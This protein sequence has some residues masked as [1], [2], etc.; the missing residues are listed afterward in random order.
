MKLLV[1]AS[2]FPYPLQ[3][4]DQL[5]LYHQIKCLAKEFEIFLY[6]TSNAKVKEKEIKELEKYCT[7]IK[8]H[9]LST[10]KMASNTIKAF[11]GSLPLQVGMFTSA[12]IQGEIK[13]FAEEHNIDH[14]YCQ[15]IRMAQNVKVLKYP[16][17]IDYMDAF[18]YGM[19]KRSEMGGIVK[20]MLYTFE[21]KRVKKY[22]KSIYESFANHVIITEQ[23]KNRLEVPGPVGVVAN[24][25]DTEFF[26][27]AG[28]VLEYDI[29]FVGNMGYLPNIDAAKM[30]VNEIL[31][32][33]NK[34]LGTNVSVLIAGARPTQ[35]V[36]DLAKT[37]NVTIGGWVQDIR[38]AYKSGR[39]FVAPIFKGIGQQNKIL[40]AMSMEIPCIVNDSVAEGLG[41]VHEK[42]CL[43]ANT[44]DEFV[45]TIIRLL[46]E[47]I[48][49]TSI[50]VSAKE[51]VLEKY[52]W[53][54]QTDPLI[55][56]IKSTGKH[57]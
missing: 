13:A 27:N 22:E 23:D 28:G 1:V 21:S 43:I 29:L 55:Q 35:E 51:L 2:R 31:P 45:D 11:F 57:T 24:G 40:E 32:K 19:V 26:T 41:I 56:M 20:R 7:A 16:K 48:I 47:P 37:D 34:K 36:I 8:V 44:I 5:R 53:S 25:V 50:L 4:G 3:K 10:M 46:E 18:G 33:L 30:L 15:L 6:T 12:L 9:N 38:S 49:H 17:T 52:V 54:K 39:I 42:H 14:V